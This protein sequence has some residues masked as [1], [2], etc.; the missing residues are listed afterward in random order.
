MN[1][2]VLYTDVVNASQTYKPL[3]VPD[4]HASQTYQL[5]G[6]LSITGIASIQQ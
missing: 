6:H 4:V 3:H 5:Q 2:V 1:I